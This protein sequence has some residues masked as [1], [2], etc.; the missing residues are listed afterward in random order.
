METNWQK[1]ESALAQGVRAS[2]PDE[3][4]KCIVAGAKTLAAARGAVLYLLE[5]DKSEFFPRVGDPSTVA[6][7]PPSIA[8]DVLESPT[9][10]TFIEAAL[11]KRQ[12][13]A[14]VTRHDGQPCTD[15]KS[16]V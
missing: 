12:T 7:A 9:P 13:I 10:S 8:V 1:L 11:Q 16:V 2:S 14:R 3:G 5:L 15:R 4:M 6:D